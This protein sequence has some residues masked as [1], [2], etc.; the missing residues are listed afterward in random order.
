MDDFELKGDLIIPLDVGKKDS[1][2]EYR[3][4][5]DLNS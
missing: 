4:C 1:K 2:V 3:K 5:V